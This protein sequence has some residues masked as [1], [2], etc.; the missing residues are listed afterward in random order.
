[1]NLS[2]CPTSRPNRLKDIK[3]SDYIIARLFPNGCK[4]IYLFNGSSLFIPWSWL[5]LFTTFNM[6][7]GDKIYHLS[8]LNDLENLDNIDKILLLF[9]KLSYSIDSNLSRI[10]GDEFLEIL[11][12]IGTTGTHVFRDW[13]KDEFKINLDPLEYVSLDKNLEI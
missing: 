12:E 6:H 7:S 2:Y 5:D 8:K 10:N 3:I 4:I 11:G 13:C 9:S 1:M